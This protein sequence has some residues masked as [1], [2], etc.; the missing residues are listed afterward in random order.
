MRRIVTL[1]DRLSSASSAKLPTAIIRRL[2]QWSVRHANRV[3]QKAG[4]PLASAPPLVASTS[5]LIGPFELVATCT[6]SYTPADLS[7]SAACVVAT[8][9]DISDRLLM[10]AARRRVPSRPDVSAQL[11]P[12]F[13][14]IAM[15]F[16]QLWRMLVLHDCRCFVDY[17]VRE[18]VFYVFFTKFQKSVIYVFLK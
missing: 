17:S 3:R 12:A 9:A 5:Y 18:Y 13:R 11:Y 16:E 14:T 6:S 10:N 15:I 7:V 2:R 1:V 8:S 4:P